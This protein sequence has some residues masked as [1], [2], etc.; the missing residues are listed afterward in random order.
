MENGFPAEK[1]VL[2]MPMYGRGYTLA[3]ESETGYGALTTGPSERGPYTQEP[4]YMTYY[5]VGTPRSPDT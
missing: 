5:E 3:D 1:I 2:G 4:G